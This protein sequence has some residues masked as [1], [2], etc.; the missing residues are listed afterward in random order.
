MTLNITQLTSQ[1][2]KSGVAKASHFEVQVML[3]P[4]GGNS[5]VGPSRAFDDSVM[6]GLTFRVESCEIPG[7]TMAT[8]EHRFR[9]YGPVNK[10][11]Y[12]QIYGDVTMTILMSEDL[13][14]KEAME[15]WQ[16][17]IQNTGTFIEEYD[18]TAGVVPYNTRYFDD[19]TGTVIIRQY[20]EA[21]QLRSIHTLLEAYPIIVTPMTLTWS[22]DET[23]KLPVTFAYRHYKAV[24]NKQDQ[25]GLGFGFSFRIGP[26]GDFGGS[27]RLPSIGNIVAGSL[28][29]NQGILGQ[30]TNKI[31]NIRNF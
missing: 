12:S 25:P 6:R 30:V 31:F 15:I 19:Y 26:G 1:L 7:R 23:L 13:R 10:I 29:L 21:G 2:N 18:R 24:Y 17:T 27:I 28:G 4:I 9:N 5:F 14:E 11:P 22:S 16:D 8:T 3:P 20:G